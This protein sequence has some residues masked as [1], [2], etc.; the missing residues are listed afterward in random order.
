MDK[1]IYSLVFQTPGSTIR[2]G[3]LGALTFRAGWYIY[4]GSA[5]SSGGLKRLERHISLA[6]LRN[7]KPK[8]HVDY[9]LTSR[10]F[11]LVYAVFAVTADC[12]ECRL[13]RELNDC[14]IPKFGCSDCSCLSHLLYRQGDPKQE[15]LAAFR[16]LQLDP[17]IKTIINPQV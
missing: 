3:A 14:G 4:V 9:L 11:S 1:G 2:V 16:E 7:K 15:I 5:L 17:V 6:Q 10:C 13:A 8:W 12:L